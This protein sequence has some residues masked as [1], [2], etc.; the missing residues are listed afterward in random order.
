MLRSDNHI[1]NVVSYAD[2]DWSDLNLR[3]IYVG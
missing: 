1:C 2:A 3:F